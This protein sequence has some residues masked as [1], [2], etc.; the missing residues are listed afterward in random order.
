MRSYYRTGSRNAGDGDLDAG[1]YEYSQVVFKTFEKTVLLPSYIFTFR[2]L[3]Q[4]H[5]LQIFLAATPPLVA[6]AAPQL[7]TRQATKITV[8]LSKEYQTMDGFGTSLAFQR[9]NLIIA[10]PATKQTAVMDLLFS[11]TT[12]AGFTILR[13]G[14]GSSPDSSSDH[15]NTI[16]PKS[17]GSPTAT[18]NYVWDG[19]DSG[20]FWVSQQ[21]A[22]VYGVKQFYADAWSAPGFMKSNGNDANGG[23]L[24][25]S[26][27]QAFAHYLIQYISYYLNAG[28]PITYLGFLNEPDYTYVILTQTNSELYIEANS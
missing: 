4:M 24:S 22:S 26:W 21:A 3:G 15:M 8:D 14:L 17:P 28:V 11:K 27:Q 20:Q 23:T 18:P 16:E 10:L 9:A 19:K 6:A 25:D 7:G 13:N 5:L 2:K 1:F 12:G